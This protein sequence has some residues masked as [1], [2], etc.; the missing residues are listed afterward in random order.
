MASDTDDGSAN[1][2]GSMTISELESQVRD[3]INRSRV[4]HELMANPA[5]W[6]V[7]CS[8]LDIVGDTEL[9]LDS[10]LNQRHVEDAGLSYLYVYGAMQI[11]QTQQDAVREICEVLEVV[12]P[13]SPELLDI[14]EIRNNSV[15]HPA[16]RKK[17]KAESSNFIVRISIS[18]HGFTLM[19]EYL[20]G[21]PYR[22]SH[23]DIPRLIEIQ[24]N[25]LRST[26]EEVLNKMD[27]TES[28]HRS[29]H[30]DEKL[31]HAF[32]RTLS[33]YFSKIFEAIHDEAHF[34][35]G[36]MH[37]TL[38]SECVARFKELL[39]KRG[40]WGINASI[41]YEYELLEYPLVELKS[42]FTDGATSKLNVKDAYIFCSFIHERLENLQQFA[43]EIDEKYAK[44]PSEE[45]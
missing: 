1:A 33:Y 5:D 17:G 22:Q 35:L 41:D 21:T 31:A 19:T 16:R 8:S 6:K 36:A 24:R 37:V 40:E 23:V 9:A 14:R 2:L 3:R 45:C 20:D 30:R 34:S 7:L 39:E 42:F 29:A 25:V 13:R 38:V 32:P 28:R 44:S 4:Q 26:L 15:G 18:Q 11:L 12:V 10:Y 27:E 43:G